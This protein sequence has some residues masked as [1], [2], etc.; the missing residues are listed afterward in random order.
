MLAMGNPLHHSSLEDSNSEHSSAPSYTSSPCQEFLAEP[1]QLCQAQHRNHYS[2]HISLSYVPHS[3]YKNTSAQ[4]S[5]RLYRGYIDEGRGHDM[6]L[7]RM[8]IK[9]QPSSCTN[10]HYEYCYEDAP[11]Y[12]QRGRL[13]PSHLKLSW[14]PSLQEYPQ[15]PS[16]ALP[17]QVVSDELISWHQRCQLQPRSLDRQGAVCIWNLPLHESPLSHQHDFYDQVK[18]LILLLMV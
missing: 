18:Y 12:Q 16:R 13:I 2:N 8:Y 7:S 1:E 15:H 3:S 10:G 11:L 4:I 14:V 9:R 17:P 5:P 6:D